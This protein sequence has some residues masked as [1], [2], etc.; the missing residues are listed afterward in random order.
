MQTRNLTDGSVVI[1]LDDMEDWDQFKLENAAEL[2]AEFG[3]F[4]A[5]FRA[6][7]TNTFLIGGGA[8]PATV[9]CFREPEPDQGIDPADDIRD[10]WR[11]NFSEGF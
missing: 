2:L 5:A 11:A 7:E 6:V 1:E 9:V 4:H 8:S 3:S 10:K